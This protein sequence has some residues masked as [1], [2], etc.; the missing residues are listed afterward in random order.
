MGRNVRPAVL[1]GFKID[2]STSGVANIIRCDENE[3]ETTC[4][5]VHGVLMD[6]DSE[7][8][9]NRVLHSEAGYDLRVERFFEYG[10]DVPVAA[11]V[12]YLTNTKQKNG[13]SGIPQERYLRII[14]EGMRYHG[15]KEEYIQKCILSA[16]HVPSRKPHEYLSFPSKPEPLP[17]ISYEAYVQRA[18]TIPCFIVGDR[19]I[20]LVGNLP[21]RDV[22]IMRAI[23]AKA[24]GKPDFTAYMLETL[25]DPNL[26]DTDHWKWA[27]DQLVDIFTSTGIMAEN[28][29]ISM[30][31]VKEDA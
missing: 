31:I 18:K 2:F 12:C 9:W 11:N 26:P 17:S 23:F 16:D 1:L 21:P 25:Y 29:C 15:V 22:P 4:T 13:K 24:V 3:E 10:S 8:T 6:F 14:A 28:T 19:V 5:C 30:R 7:E 27:I 20:D